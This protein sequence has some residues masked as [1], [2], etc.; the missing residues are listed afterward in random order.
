MA[1]TST[2]VKNRWN[3]KNYDSFYVRVKKGQKQV[4]ADHAASKGLSLNGYINQ[5][6]KSDMGGPE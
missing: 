3:K 1:K 4:I 2:A 5:L 6:I